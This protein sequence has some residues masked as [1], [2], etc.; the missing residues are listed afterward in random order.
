MQDKIRNSREIIEDVENMCVFF[1]QENDTKGCEMLNQLLPEITE[2]IT[3]VHNPEEQVQLISS[4]Q[5]ALQALEDEQW[6][7]LADIFQYELCDKLKG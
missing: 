7:M 3:Q 2:L 4:L 1:Y 5:L 6:I